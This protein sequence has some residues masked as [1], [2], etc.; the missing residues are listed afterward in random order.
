MQG[1]KLTQ[2]L[3]YCVKHNQ[4][5]LGGYESMPPRKILKNKMLCDAFKATKPYI[6]LCSY[7]IAILLAGSVY[8]VTQ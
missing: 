4:Q 1:Q 5:K 6:V 8:I 2:K 3:I 7:C